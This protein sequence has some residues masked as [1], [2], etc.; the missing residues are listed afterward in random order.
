MT[1]HYL[2]VPEDHDNPSGKSIRIAFA[3]FRGKGA[4]AGNIPTI[5]LT[6]GPGGRAL[7]STDRWY[8]H[9]LR[10]L[11]DLIIVDQRGIGLSSPLPDVA[12]RTF[13][14]LADDLSAAEERARTWEV[15]QANAR[16]IR[17]AGIDVTRYNSTQNARDFGMLMEALDY[18]QYHLYGS[19]Y[20]TRLAAGIMRDFPERV[21]AAILNGPANL[22]GKALEGRFPN[23]IRALHKLYDACAQDPDC[24]ATYP[25]LQAT[26]LEGLAGLAAEPLV[27]QLGGIDY[28][29]NPQDAVYLL[30]YLLYRSSGFE[31][32]PPYIYAIR[33]RDVAKVQELA[34]GPMQFVRAP[35]ITV[36]YAFQAYE[37][38]S[39]ATPA[40]VEAAMEAAP[41]LAY[42]L[43]WFQAFIPHLGTWSRARATQAEQTFRGIRVPALVIV[44]EY[45]PVTP[46]HH[47]RMF[48]EAI[49]AC[50]VIR[51]NQFGHGAGGDCVFEIIRAFLKDPHDPIDRTC[52]EE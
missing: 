26:L 32:A 21:H 6:G 4:D 11:G 20:G 9:E 40:A 10:S 5:Y 42:G 24:N 30:R 43:A 14:I 29:I 31:T 28:A 17:E 33:D 38:W 25:D 2:T 1:C 50:Q 15:M 13:R 23:L 45:D 51:L 8:D 44:N 7:G 16:E 27:V 35:G 36:F 39:D 41:E 22:D 19:S 48:E 12:E 3:I 47:T 18:D 46:P 37:E 49:N 34:R 52:L